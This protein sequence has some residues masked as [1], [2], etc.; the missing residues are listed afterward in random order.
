MADR[1]KEIINSHMG[2]GGT[3]C[4]CCNDFNKHGKRRKNGRQVRRILRKIVKARMTEELK[5]EV[6]DEHNND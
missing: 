5:E 3:K 1:F 4:D 6:N 2:P